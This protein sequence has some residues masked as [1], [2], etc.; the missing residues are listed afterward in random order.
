M[1]HRRR[2][3]VSVF[4]LGL[5]ALF[6]FTLIAQTPVAGDSYPQSLLDGLRWR[7]VG[8]MRGG[9]SFGVAGVA[10]EPNTFYFGSVGGGVWK[11]ENAGRTWK[12]I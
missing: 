7:D 10:S 6:S 9:R 1:D 2:W 4:A 5:V 12:P 8:P 11:T 3:S